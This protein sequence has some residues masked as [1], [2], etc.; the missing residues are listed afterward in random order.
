MS[1]LRRIFLVLFIISTLVVWALAWNLTR[2]TSFHPS[3]TS[4][5]SDTPST[6]QTVQ[7]ETDPSA[8]AAQNSGALIGSVIASAT[9]LIGFIVT[10]MISWRKEKRDAALAD[11]QYKKLETELE[12]SRLELEQLKKTSAKKKPKK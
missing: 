11:V 2:S 12:K 10:T 4:N 5:P 3:P 8:P 7:P 1:I 6:P 9:S